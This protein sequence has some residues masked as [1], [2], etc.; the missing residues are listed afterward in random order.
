VAAAQQASRKPGRLRRFHERVA[1]KHGR[2]TAHVALARK[3]LEIVY[4]LLTRHECYKDTTAK[5][6]T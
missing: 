5:S 6:E 3:M 4:Y 2:K 1:R